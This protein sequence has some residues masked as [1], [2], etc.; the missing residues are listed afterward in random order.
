M[1]TLKRFIQL[2]PELE[3]VENDELHRELHKVSP[4]WYIF[5]ERARG[6]VEVHDTA[7]LGHGEIWTSHV[8][9][10]QNVSWKI[11]HDALKF[12]SR[13][14]DVNETLDEFDRAK[15]KN[16]KLKSDRDKRARIQ[17]AMHTIMGG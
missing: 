4:S 6:V 7:I 1:D 17:H 9:T 3:L 14:H 11:V 2:N 5:I 13:V 10:E 8:M 12:N 16:L 15:D